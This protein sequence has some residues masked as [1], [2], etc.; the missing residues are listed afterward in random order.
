MTASLGNPQP[1]DQRR[2]SLAPPLA[3]PARAT[4][5]AD[6]TIN[7]FSIVV[8]GPVYDFFLRIG[9][10]RF[11]LPNILRRIAVLVALAW[12]PLLV[13]SIRDGVAFGQ[14]KLPLLYDFSMYGRFMLGLPLLVLAEIVID[15]A[16]RSAV[17]EFVHTGIVAEQDIPQFDK[18]LQR[19]Q[20][21]RDSAIP[22]VILLALAFFPVFLFQHEWVGGAISSWHTNA[23]GLTSA[24]W[25]YA[26]FSAP[27]LRFITYRWA[28]RYF[29][30]SALLARIA[31]L[32]LIL[33]PTHPDHAAGL[34]FLGLAQRRFGILFCALGC[35]FAGR[36]A[37]SMMF[38]AAPLGAFKFLMVGFVVL[39]IL[40]GLA[41]LLTL[42]PKL[43]RVRKAGLLDYGRLA[44]RYTEQFDR[45]WVHPLQAPTEP[46]LGT[47]DIQS[48]AD[49]GNSFANVETMAIAPIT[50]RLVIQLSLQAALPLIPVIILGTPTPEL[51]HELLKMV[52]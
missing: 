1:S 26:V 4:E 25:W 19:T 14:V 18:V 44:N 15:P 3:Q 28:Y 49:L 21:L 40:V 7:N 46:L 11:G 31:H 41:P 22:E 48:L 13:L 33:V 47:A 17:A 2:P 43:A 42:A 32:N 38:E 39:S 5:E 45:K 50:K 37:N 29:V 20:R 9:L 35:A 16:I 23:H 51:V 36:V 24:G 10:L 34:N 8:G 30:W 6:S 12:L 52:V 27:L